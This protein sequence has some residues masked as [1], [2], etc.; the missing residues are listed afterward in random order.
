LKPNRPLRLP[1]EAAASCLAIAANLLVV[2]MLIAYSSPLSATVNSGEIVASSVTATVG[3]TIDAANGLSVTFKWTT[4]HASNSIVII[5]NPTNYN[6]G[7]N[8]PTRQVTNATLTTSHQVVVDHIPTTSATWAYYV[9]SQQ[10]NGTWASY[11]GPSTQSCGTPAVPGCGGTYKTFTVN[12]Y[13]ANGTPMFTLWPIGSKSVYQGDATRNPSYNDLYIQLNPQLLSGPVKG[14]IMTGPT[15]TS[16]STGKTVSTITPV[17]LCGLKAPSNP[18]PVGWDGN[19]AING[20]CYNANSISWGTYVRLRVSSAAVPGQYTFKATFQAGGTLVV[21]SWTFTVLPTA[22]F[23]PTPPSSSPQ[24]SGLATWQSN[25][26]NPNPYSGSGGTPYASAE[27]WCSNNQQTNPWWS[28]DNANFLGHFDTNYNWGSSYFRSFNY[29]G[30]RVYQQIADYDYN[31][32]GMPGYQDPTARAH[33]NRCAQEIMDPFKNDW[34]AS[35]GAMAIEA[36][37]FP[38]GLEMNYIRTGDTT[39]LQAIGYMANSFPFGTMYAFSLDPSY[40]RLMGYLL[41]AELAAEMTGSPRNTD[42]VPRQVDILLGTLDQLRNLSFT[43]PAAQI[44]A[45]PFFIGA[46][47]EALIDYYELDVAEG[48]QPDARV[49]LEIKK[50][51]DWLKTNAYVASTHTLEYNFYDL[52]N[53]PSLVA[54][55]GFSATELNDLVAP[56][57]AWY[58]SLTG[59]AASLTTGDDLFNH[60]FDSAS[61]YNPK[62]YLGN[63]W[64]WSAKEFNQIY[65]W[66]FDFVRWRTLPNAVSAVMPAANTCENGSSP[67]NAPWPDQAPPI[68]FTWM[69]AAQNSA[70]RINNAVSSIRVT[71]TTATLQFNTYKP[72]TAVVYYGAT[73]P[74]KCVMQPFPNFGLQTCLASNY[75]NVS[76][77]VIAAYNTNTTNQY[78]IIGSPNIYNYSVTLIGLT[79]NTTYHWRP[80][81]TDLSGNSAAYVDQTFTTSP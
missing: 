48:N 78:D 24:L 52:P 60:A 81:V 28:I 75:A 43:N 23:S 12:A 18:V 70:P 64:T 76:T 29:D 53:N 45:H 77:P 4:L 51:L 36:N 41:D 55:A 33:W 42:F 59:D 15:V 3:T 40:D 16:A 58:W 65:K 37:I 67:C 35:R 25:M 66:S 73:A 5:E 50:T 47:M 17:H 71:Q 44:G 11:P 74:A 26:V 68:Q 32:P 63:G 9:V 7:N 69:A 80:L 13:N 38:F 46:V 39:N 22:T 10:S 31:T 49:P 1:I 27:W 56:A 8:V 2:L 34:I 21:V 20:L 62:G 72:A 57:Y 79:P 6:A 19:I 61:F 14:L 54:G 30:G